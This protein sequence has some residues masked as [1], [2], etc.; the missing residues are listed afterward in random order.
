MTAR[1]L[2]MKQLLKPSGNVC[3]HC[4][5][6]ASHYIKIMMDGIFGH[7]NFINE[8]IWSYRTGGVS[9]KWLAKKYDVILCYAKDIK[10]KY[11]KPLKERIY[12]EKPFFTTEKDENGKYYSDVYLR[13]VWDDIKPLINVSKERLGHPTQ[14]PIALLRRIIELFCPQDGIVFDPFCGCGATIYST[15]ELNKDTKSTQKMD[16]L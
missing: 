11:F 5:P 1:L 2:L 15:H 6:S 13:D 4:D 12:Y 14:K 7:K 10:I 9:K 3:L 8:A 16:W